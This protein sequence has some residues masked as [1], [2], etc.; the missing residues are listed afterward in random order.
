M[1]IFVKKF[2]EKAKLPFRATP[3]S[4]GADLFACIDEDVT[5][6]PGERRLIPTGIAIELLDKR[7]GG[8]VFPR[9]SVSSKY[10]VSLANCVGVIDSDYRG[11]IKI[12]LINHSDTPYVIRDGD[13]IA[14]LV[15]LPVLLPIF[16]ERDE[17]GFTDR[18]A[19]GFGSTGR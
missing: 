18:G 19:G 7:S 2:S 4:A 16:T 13:R 5:L 9:S 14:Q 1:N 15:I 11:E 12:P 6:Q 8:F 17:L 3:G 10:G